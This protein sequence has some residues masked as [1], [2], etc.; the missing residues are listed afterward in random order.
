MGVGLIIHVWEG[1]LQHLG[2]LSS[3]SPLPP[4]HYYCLLQHFVCTVLQHAPSVI[5]EL[6]VIS[7]AYVCVVSDTVYTIRLA[8][9]HS[10]LFLTYVQLECGINIRAASLINK[11]VLLCICLVICCLLSSSLN[12]TGIIS[13]LSDLK[14]YCQWLFEQ[15]N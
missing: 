8:I 6:L 10:V 7:R 13:E 5:A 12:A 3:S 14:S 9:I 2:W 4:F 15:N 1:Y 11:S